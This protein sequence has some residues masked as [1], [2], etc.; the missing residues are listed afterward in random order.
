MQKKFL[1]TVSKKL[2]YVPSSKIYVIL[3]IHL[4]FD[5]KLTTQNV[6]S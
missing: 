5:K 1:F 4:Q 2:F 6:S 3:Y